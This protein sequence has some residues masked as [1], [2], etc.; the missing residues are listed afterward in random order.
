MAEKTRVPHDVMRLIDETVRRLEALIDTS[1]KST[2]GVKAEHKEA[3]RPYV[4][5][6]ILYNV[7]TLKKWAVG[8]IDGRD[9]ERERG[10]L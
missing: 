3:V 8:E 2:C 4:D 9:I 1:E 6:W 10:I 5:T 7:Q